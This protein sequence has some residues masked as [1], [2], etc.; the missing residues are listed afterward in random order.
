MCVWN[1][2]NKLTEKELLHYIKKC[3]KHIVT[4]KL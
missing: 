4:F 2:L 3:V 1:D